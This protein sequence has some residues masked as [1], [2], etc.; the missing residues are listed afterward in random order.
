MHK[1]PGDK[2]CCI[3]TFVVSVQALV[4]NLSKAKVATDIQEAWAD[5]KQKQAV[6]DE[7]QALEKNKTQE[8]VRKPKGKSSGF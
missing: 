6:S 7:L 2:V 3:W 1:T 5:S 4:S 8:I